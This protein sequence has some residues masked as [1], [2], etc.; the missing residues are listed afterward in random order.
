MPVK[1]NGYTH[2]K[3]D[4]RRQKRKIE[5]LKRQ[6]KYNALT[7]KEKLNLAKI[8]GGKKEISK[9]EKRFSEKFDKQ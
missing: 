5:A 8:R 3:L 1:Q 7:L 4:A 9:L 6:A 2:K